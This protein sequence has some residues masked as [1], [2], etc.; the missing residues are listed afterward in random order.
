MANPLDN[1]RGWYAA[2]PPTVRDS[3]GKVIGLLPADMKYGSTFKQTHKDIERAKHDLD[4]VEQER[5]KLLRKLVSHAAQTPYYQKLFT[6]HFGGTPDINQFDFADLAKLPVLTKE[7]LRADPEAFLASPLNEVDTASTSGSSGRPLTFYLDKNRGSKEFAYITSFW[8]R[9]GFDYSKH[10]RAVLRGVHFDDVDEKP[11]QYDAALKELRFSPFHLTSDKMA[12]FID[13]MHEY[14]VDYLHGYPSSIIVL[15]DYVLREK[16]T[17]PDSLKGILPVSEATLPHQLE[18]FKQAF[19]Q[20]QITKYYGMS[21]KILIAG[22]VGGDSE[23]YDFE[24]LYGYAELLDDKNQPITAEGQ[25]GRIVGTGFISMAMPL[26]RYDTEDIAD[27][28]HAATRENHYCFCVRN[29]R[30]RWGEEYA[31]GFNNEL[32]SMSAINIHSTEYGKVHIFQLYQEKP[33][34]VVIKLVPK[35]GVTAEMLEPFRAE[36]QAKVGDTIQF[37]LEMLEDIPF[38]TENGKRKFIDQQID[39]SPYFGKGKV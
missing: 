18:R 15:A 26:L 37:S 20:C 30:G 5:L 14:Q 25:S 7:E 29:I 8:S 24:P 6:K 27:F 17:L 34:E 2:S 16:V 35:A 10:K 11:W 23:T 39:L 13:L 28:A 38:N 3:L 31:L 32:T 19:P 22:Q 21:E 33:G 9:I 36:L 1:L 4:F 12:M